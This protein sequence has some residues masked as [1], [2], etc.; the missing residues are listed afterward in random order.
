MPKNRRRGPDWRLSR[1]GLLDAPARSVSFADGG[2][3]WRLSRRG[4]PDAPTRRWR[5]A[6]RRGERCFLAGDIADLPLPGRF[7][8]QGRAP[9]SLG[10]AATVPEKRGR[11]FFAGGRA[12]VP[13]FDDM[14]IF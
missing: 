6:W 9:R 11:D 1:E 10:A 8:A 5:P 3:D 7:L 14:R 4:K 12:F 2:L 13:F